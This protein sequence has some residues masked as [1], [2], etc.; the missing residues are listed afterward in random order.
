MMIDCMVDTTE[1][2]EFLF[3]QP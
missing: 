1:M 3:N 2:T